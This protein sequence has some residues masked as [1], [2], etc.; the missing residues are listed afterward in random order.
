MQ[1]HVFPLLVGSLTVI[2]CST[3][4][5]PAGDDA[6]P[7]TGGTTSMGS[8]GT[9]T[10]GTGTGGTGSPTTGGT[11]NTST[12]GTGV[13]TGG[14]GVSTGGTGV[15]TGGTGVGT[16]GTSMG[17]MSQGATGGTSSMSGAGGGSAGGGMVTCSN[18]DKSILPIDSTG[19]VDKSCNAC[20]IQGAF[21]WYADAN[22]TPSLMC[23]G[24]ACVA[25]APPYQAGAPGPGMCIS[26]KATGTAADWGAGIGL[27]LN[28]S[29]GM[30]SV[31]G[32][33]DATKAACGNIT[34]FDITLTGNTG[35]MPVRIGFTTS[36]DG[37]TV[38]PF[39]PVGDPAGMSLALSGSSQIVIKN[40]VIPA[41][42]MK[43]DPSPPDPAKIYDMQ[44]QVA[45][46]QA[47]AGTPFS[48]CVTSIKPVTD[49]SGG[50]GGGG[51]CKSSSVGTISSNTGVQ[52]LGSSGLG[53]QN[54]VNNLDSGSQSVTGMYGTGCGALTV[55]TTGIKSKN[56]APASYP[57]LVDG[58]HWGSWSGAYTQGSVKAISALSSVKSS[59][60]FT[61]PAGNKWDVSYDM[62]VA[63]S[64]GISAPD[65]NTL[66][67]MVWLDYSNSVTTNPIGSKLTTSFSAAGTTWEVWYGATGA[68]HTV[69][70]RRSPGTAPVTDLDL[71]AFLKD[72]VTHGTGSTSWN[73]LSVEAGFELF[74]ATAGGSID[75][76]SCSI[77]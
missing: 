26:G 57:S 21:Y 61:P 27:S 46:D 8:G 29:G 70:Y 54:N 18:T 28:D 62:W 16:G 65:G 56:D 20:G 48:L 34:G 43:T 24:A 6:V 55:N 63:Q 41:D 73:L 4:N 76:Y 5:P 64:A 40:A 2:A 69:S 47:K 51:N 15:A 67:V 12:G 38:A 71:L 32:S 36:G 66:E 30:T 31:K 50:G 77:N 33:F 7:I 72:A 3:A 68:W 22:T 25:N 17:G 13:A 44:I 74:D 23:N 59:F 52:A 53:Y 1:K 75:S 35:G 45:A 49:G 58:W 60:A 14:T 10:G 42:W 19:W 39:I 11:G 37:T 9:G